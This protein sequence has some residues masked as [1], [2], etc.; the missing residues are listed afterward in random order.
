[1][2]RGDELLICDSRDADR[3][4][5][6]KLFEGLGYVCTTTSSGTEARELTGK[7]FFP[8]ALVDLDVGR[9]SAGLDVLRAIRERSKPTSLVLL[10]NRRSFESAVEALRLGVLDVI[11]KVPEQI[12]RL[13][14]AVAAGCDRASASGGDD[15][16]FLRDVNGVLDEAF[17]IMLDMG[18]KQHADVSLGSPQTFRARVLVVEHDTEMLKELGGLVGDK[19]WE[20]LAEMTGGA[21]LDKAASQRLDI[22]AVRAELPD[23]R[24]S[25]VVKTLQAQ[26]P[27][28]VGLVYTREG[29]GHIGTFRE[30]KMDDGERPFRGAAHLIKRIEQLADQLSATQ[31]DRR[32]IQAFR[33]A[34]EDFFRRYAELKMRL[35][36]LLE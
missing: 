28:M 13:Q 7:K 29:D 25:M 35:G 22:A 3:E 18:R 5:M 32:V 11:V 36:R 1:M 23:L 31:R 24:G 34:N 16:A 2:A 27:D 14:E 17:R 26:H 15:T 19:P 30:G 6:R 9:P 10:T 4:G 20:I 21:A 12:P 33:S 8:V